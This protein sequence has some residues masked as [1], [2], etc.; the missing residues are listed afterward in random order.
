MRIVHLVC[1]SNYAGVERYVQRLALA[2]AG[3]GH[4]VTVLGGSP[5]GMEPPLRS[6]GVRW[7][8]AER[9]APAARMLSRLRHVDVVNSHMTAADVAA[10]VSGIR[11]RVPVVSTRHFAQ[12][13]GRIGP[14]RI[15][16]LLHGRIAAEIAIGQAV[17]ATIRRPS[18]V[19][20]TGVEDAP[21]AAPGDSRTILM[22]QRLQ[23]EKHS[24]LGVLAFAASGLAE[25]GWRLRIA[26]DGP[27][28]PQLDALRRDLDVADAV[29]LLGFRP[30][31]GELLASSAVLLATCPRE[32]LGLTVLEAMSRAVPVVAAAAAGHLDLLD[33]ADPLLLFRPD[34][35][36][37][38]AARLRALADDPS[39]RT[40]LG[41]ELQR[42]Q[43]QRF[44]V[45]AQAAETEAV[46]REAVAR[47]RT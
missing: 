8:P 28:R 32:G 21:A 38:A 13:R 9:A 14:V 20:H 12:P 15:D 39:A 2:Q 22:A 30:D 27:E 41:R 7:A 24:W 19:V 37:Q 47:W 6:A 31:V 40:D 33:G 44:T 35:E 10:A 45:A 42:R 17:A 29:E 34:D 5:A 16:T 36:A 25:Q 46:Y 26:G 4:D 43:R 23:P 3:D 18:T 1:S 11:T